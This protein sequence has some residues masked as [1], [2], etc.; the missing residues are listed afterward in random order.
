ISKFIK[1]ISQLRKQIKDSSI[2]KIRIMNDTIMCY[3]YKDE[4]VSFLF[5][6]NITT[7]LLEDAQVLLYLENLKR[8]DIST[9]SF[10]EYYYLLGKWL[11]A[12]FWS[13]A[14]KKIIRINFSDSVY[15]YTWNVA[16]CVYKLYHTQ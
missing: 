7:N 16:S 13:S 15:H 6:Q 2:T 4:H 12:Q 5:S 9:R 1:N 14:T 8:T 11:E 3:N 10:E